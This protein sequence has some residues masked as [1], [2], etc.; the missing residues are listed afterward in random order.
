MSTFISRRQKNGHWQVHPDADIP[1]NLA[2]FSCNV[3]FGGSVIAVDATQPTLL[4]DECLGQAQ[5]QNL[6]LELPAKVLAK[7]EATNLSQIHW[8]QISV[9]WELITPNQFENFQRQCI[10]Q[11]PA[12][13]FPT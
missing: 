13:S 8:L 6:Q 4:D 2:F 5:I 7:L 3:N 1:D 11:I 12:M 9:G 10:D